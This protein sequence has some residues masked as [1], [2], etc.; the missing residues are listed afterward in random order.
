MLSKFLYLLFFVLCSYFLFNFI[1]E[2]NK[3]VNAWYLRSKR[4]RRP[5]KQ[6]GEEGYDPYDFESMSEDED[7]KNNFRQLCQI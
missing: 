5:R 2:V 3:C 7:G 1:F 6:P 4:V